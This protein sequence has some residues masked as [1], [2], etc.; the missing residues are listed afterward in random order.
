MADPVVHITAGI[1]DSGTGNITTLGQTLVDGANI[2]V[3]AT[4]DAAVTAGATGSLSAKLRSISRDIV[5]AIVLA[6]GTN[7]IGKVTIDQTT[8]GTTNLVS[9]GTSGTV[10]AKLQ[11]G[12]GNAITSATRGSERPLSVQIVDGSGTQVTAFSGSGGTASNFGSSLPSAGTA[13]GMSDGTAMQSPR[14]FD[15]DTGVGTQYIMG[16]VERVA[17]SGGS[18]AKSFNSG[19]TDAGTVRTVEATDGPVPSFLGAKT[20]AKNTA[21]DSTSTTAMSVWKQVSASVQASAT[22]LATLAGSLTALGQTT[23]SASEPVTIA[24][25]QKWQTGLSNKSFAVA[26]TTLTRPANT[27]AYSAADSISDNATAGSVTALTATV[28]DTND[29]LLFLSDILVSST[30]TG[31]AGKRIRAYL[32]NS[33]P[34]ASTGVGA[35]DNAAFSNKKAGYIGSMSGVMESGFSDG[36]V[37][38]LVPSFNDGA[39][40]GTPNAAASGFIVTKPVSGAKTLFVQYQ[41]VD[42]F[43][44]SAN[45]TTII[46]T[47]RGWQGRAT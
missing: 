45:S 46:G 40:S 30:D 5:N 6:A 34:T 10:N 7:V 17:A 18:I 2:A 24:Q 11:D 25:D 27:T 39:A 28:S 29:D 36:S 1:P 43:T 33:D 15:A 19:T 8:P 26:F 21:T 42:G 20:D 23:M 47:V 31:L 12:A 22:S 16:N 44:P 38:R 13:A 14:V 37:G 32:Y 3:G 9:I 4:T 41:A 35:G